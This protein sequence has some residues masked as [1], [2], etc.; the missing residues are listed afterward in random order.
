MKRM[1]NRVNIQRS[2]FFGDRLILQEIDLNNDITD[3][4]GIKVGHAQ[5]ADNFTGVTVVLPPPSGARAGIHVGG[6]AP[7]TRQMDSLNPLHIVDRIHAVC[8][9]GG[10]AFGLDAAGGVLAGLE[11]DKVGFQVVGVTVPIVPTAAIFDLNFGS[12]KVRPDFALG[13]SAYKNAGAGP[14]AQGSVG[15]GGRGNDR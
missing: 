1:G 7:S 3:V 9:C 13:L 2:Q 4:P 5:S 10:S 6:S 15:V 12:G 14:I 8:L 11:A